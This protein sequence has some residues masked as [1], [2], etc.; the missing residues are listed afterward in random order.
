MTIN[1]SETLK[2]E[3]E[4]YPQMNWSAYAREA[5]EKKIKALALFE[6]FTKESEGTIEESITLGRAVNKNMWEKH[7]KKIFEKVSEKQQ[8]QLKKK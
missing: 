4:K 6:A 5:F 2:K 8:Q 7:Y 3:M 1:V